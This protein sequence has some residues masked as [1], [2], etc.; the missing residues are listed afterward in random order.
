MSA[1]NLAPLI[2]VDYPFTISIGLRCTYY[3]RCSSL[4]TLKITL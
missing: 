2:K 1:P 3:S 4:L